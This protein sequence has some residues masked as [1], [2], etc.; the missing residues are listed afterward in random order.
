MSKAAR[1]GGGSGYRSNEGKGFEADFSL[2]LGVGFADPDHA[3]AL[4]ERRVFIKDNC[5]SVHNGTDVRLL[6]D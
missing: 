2:L 5:E 3:A 1:R 4:A 6:C